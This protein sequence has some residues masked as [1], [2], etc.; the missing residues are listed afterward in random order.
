MSKVIFSVRY[1]INPAKRED[2]LSVIRELKNLLKAEGLES[3]NVYEEKSKPNHFQELFTFSSMEAYEKFEDDQNERINILINKL[4]E[5]TEG[6][7]SKYTLLN[8]LEL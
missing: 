3:Y 1:E 6:H 8:E 5:L 7:T 2:Y 4:S